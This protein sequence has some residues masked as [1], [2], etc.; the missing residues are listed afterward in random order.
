MSR[1]TRATAGGRLRTHPLPP[2]GFNPCAASPLELRR[3]GLPQRPD[4][5][6]RP[7]LAARWDEI[8]SRKRKLTY[9][10][11]SGIHA[12]FTFTAPTGTV[13]SEN[14][15]EWILERPEIGSVN[16]PLPN[17]GEIYFDS[18]MGGRSLDF[19]ADGGTDT[20]L[21]TGAHLADA[22]RIDDP[23]CDP[24]RVLTSPIYTT[25]VGMTDQSVMP[26]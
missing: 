20:V 17:F 9:N 11:T 13:S 10:V 3:Y 1:S 21:M 24:L 22:A 2:H 7:Q 26:F 12:G 6:I 4:P 25:V 5:V 18:A 19:L 16:P 8:F 23:H 15:V 14:Q